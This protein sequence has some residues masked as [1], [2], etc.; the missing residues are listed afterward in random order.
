M[1]KEKGYKIKIN[2]QCT[3]NQKES[4]IEFY[5]KNNIKNNVFYFT[6]NILELILDSDLAISRC[7]AS[8]AAELVHT[9]T[10]F[11]AVPYPYSMDNHQLL[12]AKYYENKGCC[13]ILEQEN[14]NSLSLFNLLMEIMKD[15][16]K[17][18]NICE[19]MKKNGNKN[20]YI[21]IEN[22]IKE[23]I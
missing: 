16:S 8:T 10:P 9:L 23:F 12:N 18:K 4:L 17:L 13:W 2:Q 14:F 1:L 19:N 3:K 20:V 15:K 22:T 5:N 11:I 7:G 6:N 21:E